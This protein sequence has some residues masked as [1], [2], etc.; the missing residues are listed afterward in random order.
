MKKINKKKKHKK[1][2]LAVKIYDKLGEGWIREIFEFK[3][4]KERDSAV[5]QCEQQKIEWSISK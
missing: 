2:L 5:K 3:S 1:Y 4:K